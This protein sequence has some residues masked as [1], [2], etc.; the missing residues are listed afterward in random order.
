MKLS[1][2][3][4]PVITEDDNK[5]AVSDACLMLSDINKKGVGI[6]FVD[7]TDGRWLR[8]E[9][10]PPKPLTLAPVAAKAVS[11]CTHYL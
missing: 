7:Q 6:F 5:T 2:G 3:L 4:Q 10:T 1:S 11:V 9:K 8:R